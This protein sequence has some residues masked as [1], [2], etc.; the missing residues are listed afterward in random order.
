MRFTVSGRMRENLDEY[1]TFHRT[2]GNEYCHFVGIPLIVAGSATLLA[3]LAVFQLFGASVTATELVLLGVSLFYVVEARWLGVLTALWMV[4]LGELARRATLAVG[5]ALFVLGWAIQFL[6]HAV[7]ERR[8]PAFLR[9]LLHL[10]VGP[11]WL[12]AEVAESRE[13]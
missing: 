4:A 5:G 8:S 13:R 10:L 7:F 6:G 3:R 1:G 2:R 9:N 11:A 12:L